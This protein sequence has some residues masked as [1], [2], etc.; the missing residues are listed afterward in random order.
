MSWF[1][2]FLR[3][4]L[5]V[6]Q[7]RISRSQALAIAKQEAEQR[8]WPFENPDIV[9]ELRTWVVFTRGDMRPSPWIV[10]CQQTGEVVRAGVPPL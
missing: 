10:I 3:V 8:G 6:P 4:V 9:E 2:R 7:P 5:F 1:W